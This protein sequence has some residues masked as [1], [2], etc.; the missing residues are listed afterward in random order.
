MDRI[1]KILSIFILIIPILGYSQTEFHVVHKGWITKPYSMEIAKYNLSFSTQTINDCF[2]KN[3]LTKIGF[4]PIDT[5]KSSYEKEYIWLNVKI[6]ELKFFNSNVVIK[7]VFG[8][9]QH[10]LGN[11]DNVTFYIDDENG[12]DL[13]LPKTKFQRKMTKVIE[14]WMRECL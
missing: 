1:K 8:R 13:L 10:P 4:S 11:F 3:L 6:E 5:L 14:K 12:K 9:Y 2:V 7:V